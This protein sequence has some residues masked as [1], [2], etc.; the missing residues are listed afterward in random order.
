MVSSDSTSRGSLQGSISSSG[1]ASSFRITVVLLLL[2]LVL[3][4]LLSLTSF[5]SSEGLEGSVRF[6]SFE[7][8]D[9]LKG[10][11]HFGVWTLSYQEISVWI[12]PLALNISRLHGFT[13]VVP[14]DTIEL[15]PGT[16]KYCTFNF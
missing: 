8:T 12:L 9:Y 11:R 7:K 13:S 15:N 2:L 6:L 14:Q 16:R 10:L 5:S 4:V 3:Y 1:P